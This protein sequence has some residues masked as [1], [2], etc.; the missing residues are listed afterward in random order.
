M[1]VKI[2]AAFIA[3][4]VSVVTT[5][6]TVFIKPK[7][8]KKSHIDKLNEEHNH[9]Q[10]KLI[11]ETISKNK[12]SL[13]DSAESLNHRLWNFTA[14]DHRGWH[15]HESENDPNLKYYLPSFCYRF[16]ALF[17]WA[18]KIEKDMVYLD[19]TLCDKSDL[20]FIKYLKI[21][22]QFF[23]DASLFK[24]Y[25]YDNSEDKDHFYRDDFN[26]MLDSMITKDGIISF[27]DFKRKKDTDFRKIYKYISSISTDKTCLK[28]KA[29]QGFHFILMAFLSE[30]GYAFQTT[31]KEKL[32]GLAEKSPDND[33]LP[34][35]DLA[36]QRIH[37]DNNENITNS[38]NALK[39]I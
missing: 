21:L 14:N 23:W 16:A 38:V 33:L 7:L 39:R 34:H 4:G 32:K 35:F 27:T 30:Y 36:L 5:L 24:N 13:L 10:R 29:I 8:E 37:L 31:S 28:W 25:P 9:E 18:R 20:E 19:S 22:P 15:C 26:A 11:K 1:D 2:Q 17:A 12:V 6:I 3:A